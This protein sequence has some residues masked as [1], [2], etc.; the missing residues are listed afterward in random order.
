M[1]SFKILFF[2]IL[3]IL[4]YRIITK[5]K[6]YFTS[7][8]NTEEEILVGKDILVD[9][10]KENL[11]KLRFLKINRIGNTFRAISKP[12]IFSFSELIEIDVE[13]ISESKSKVKFNSKCFFPLQ[14]FDWGK[15]K[16]NSNLFFKNLIADLNE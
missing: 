5:K 15:N 12:S 16:S 7:F 8:Y 10:I 3:L 11:V 1:T 2:F 6:I 14:I 9:K 13:K 4:F